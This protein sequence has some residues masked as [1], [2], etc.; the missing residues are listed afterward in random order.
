M[1]TENNYFVEAHLNKT[2][3]YLLG[4]P[5]KMPLKDTVI[6]NLQDLYRFGLKE[7]G[8]CSSKI[9]IDVN[10]KA[11]HIGYCFI[12]KRFYEDTKEPYIAET[13]LSIE[14]YTE[15]IERQYHRPV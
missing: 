5:Y 7:Y 4:E 1:K 3:N 11:I 2:E 6:K 9:Y 14:S 13:W 10:G 12:Q 15:T 8:R